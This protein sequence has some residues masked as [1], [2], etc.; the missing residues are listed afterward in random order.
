[1]KKLLSL[2]FV[3]TL[4]ACGGSDDDI[5]TDPF[6]GTWELIYTGEDASS[7][8]TTLEVRGDGTFTETDILYLGNAEDAVGIHTGT[9]RNLGSDLN[10]LSQTYYLTL[11]SDR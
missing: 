8:D 7:Y 11:D 9:W 1:M 10:S 3:F 4:V 2:L 5:S 6:I